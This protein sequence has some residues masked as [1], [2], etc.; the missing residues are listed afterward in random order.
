MRAFEAKVPGAGGDASLALFF[1]GEGKGGDTAAN[2][3]RW[4]DQI[5][6]VPGSDTYREEFSAN[7]MTIFWVNFSGTLKPDPMAPQANERRPNSRMLAAVIEGPGGPWYFKLV[8]PDA[9]V[10]PQRDAFVAML[11]T[12]RPGDG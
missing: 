10:G 5:E 8:G 2:I 7:G 6:F 9:T 1:F 4:I 11:Q 12:V 3:Q